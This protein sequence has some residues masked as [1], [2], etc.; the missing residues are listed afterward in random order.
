MVGAVAAPARAEEARQATV[1]TVQWGENLF[2][3]S[4]RYNV[5]MDSI[6]AANGISDAASIYAGQQLII[7]NGTGV[8]A[9]SAIPPAQPAT[10]GSTVT[11]VVQ[12]GETLSRIAQ[13]YGVSMNQISNR[14]LI[15]NPSLIYVGQSLVIDPGSAVNTQPAAGTG[16]PILGGNA[17]GKRILVDL[18]DQRTYAYQDG[19]LLRT[20]VVSTGLAPFP[21]VTG[22]YSIYVKREIQTMSGPGYVTPDVPW[23]MYFYRGYGFHGT[24]WHN[25][26]GQPISHGCVNM[27]IAD[28]KWLY[29]WAPL[30][31]AVTVRW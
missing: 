13:R 30:G 8:P 16:G 11:H 19:V 17:A 25:N 2:R 21:T 10:R 1:H 28:A 31:T 14:N 18:S 29:D 24:Y 6:I 22:E 4:L 12:A 20:F 26:F 9:S 7:P 27:T 23:I 5:T 3:I 15:S